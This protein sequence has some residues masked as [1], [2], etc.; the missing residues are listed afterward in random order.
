MKISTHGLPFA[1]KPIFA[2]LNKKDDLL[3]H[4]LKDDPE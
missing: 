4:A 3:D 2:K 1:S